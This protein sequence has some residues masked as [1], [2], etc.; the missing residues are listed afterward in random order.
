MNEYM[1]GIYG[2]FFY[3]DLENAIEKAKE[4]LINRLIMPINNF[5]F[6]IHQTKKGNYSVK[7]N[8]SWEYLGNA[9]LK[10]VVVRKHKVCNS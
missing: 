7:I 6:T 10:F 1:Y 3:S 2:K 4:I 9:N 5:D 8:V